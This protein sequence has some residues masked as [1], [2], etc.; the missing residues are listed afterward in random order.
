MVANIMRLAPCSSLPVTIYI[1]QLILIYATRTCVS[2]ISA[3]LHLSP[4]LSSCVPNFALRAANPQQQ[5]ANIRDTPCTCTHVVYIVIQWYAFIQ[6]YVVVRTAT[7]EP[8]ADERTTFLWCY[9]YSGSG[10]G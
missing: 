6:W 4:H 1:S 7:A 9:V 8:K 10:G 5:A 2:C 3:Q